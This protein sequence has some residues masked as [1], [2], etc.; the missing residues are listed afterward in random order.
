MHLLASVAGMMADV[1]QPDLFFGVDGGGNCLPGPSVP[2]GL[3]RVGPDTVNG[4]TTGYQSGNDLRCF[5]H[6]HVAGTGGAGRYGNVGVL[7]CT[8]RPDGRIGSLALHEEEA[9]PGY[10]ACTL[11]RRMG[12]KLGAPIRAE[13]T[14]SHACAVHRY[15]FPEG[16]KPWIRLDLGTLISGE[17]VGGWLRRMGDR[18]LAGRADYRGGWGHT[19]PYSVFFWMEVRA[20]LEQMY[21]RS[22]FGEGSF[23]QC[24]EGPRLLTWWCSPGQRVLELRVGISFVSVAAARRSLAVE[25]GER[26][27]EEVSSAAEAAWTGKIGR[28]RVEGGTEEDRTLWASCWQRLYTMPGRMR[29]EDVPWLAVEKAHFNDLYCLWDSVRCAN[30]LFALVEPG[31]AAEL[32]ASLTEIGEQT[33]WVPDAWI[34]GGS[35][36]IQGGCSAAV[37]FAEAAA[38]GLP[39]FDAARAL[40]VLRRTQ[41]T[42]SPDPW[43]FGRYPEY[44]ERGFLPEGVPHGASRTV[45]YAFHDLCTADLAERVGAGAVADRYRK[46]ADRLWENWH[47][48]LR[49]FAPRRADGTWADF[50]PWRPNPTE[51]SWFD[52][53]F[54]EGCAHDYAL[55]GWAWLPSLV[56]RWGKEAFVAHLDRFLAEAWMWKEINLHVPWLYHYAGEPERAAQAV[57]K[58]LDRLVRPGRRGLPD[59]EDMGAWTSWWLTGAM[60]LCPVPGTDRFW[61]IPPRFDA[62]ELDLATGVTLRIERG[63]GGGPPH[64]S[65]QPLDRWW[66]RQEEIAAGGVV[67]FLGEK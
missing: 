45:E 54:Y 35:A 51:A 11:R 67:R 56:E 13:L 17:S 2:F 26:S 30:S 57:P 52:P 65:G 7:P 34:V 44:T 55:T 38:K 60:G 61:L 9:R 3:V 31:F 48:D 5:S 49:C 47:P 43:H 8:V 15:T 27:F 62:V 33:G 6:L 29:P 22:S 39:G 42:L 19:L 59:N 16:T 36:Q 41:E 23:A 20:P 18:T 50:D 12:E 58:L 1:P 46:Q 24:S 64:L 10:Y 21:A 37:L 53:H 66:V 25:L 40:A 63:S 4:E 28:F 32:V 14:A